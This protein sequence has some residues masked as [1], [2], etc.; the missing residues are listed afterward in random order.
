[1]EGSEDERDKR[2][3]KQRKRSLIP[4]TSEWKYELHKI[5]AKN[6]MQYNSIEG[7]LNAR[8]DKNSKKRDI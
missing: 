8:D 6:T 5:C 1:M 2:G 3:S 4:Y 7:K